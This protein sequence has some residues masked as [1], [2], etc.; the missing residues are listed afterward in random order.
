MPTYGYVFAFDPTGKFIGLSAEG[1]LRNWPEGAVLREARAKPDAITGLVQA[2]T[3]D[4]PACLQGI[5]W[6]RL[7]VAGEKLNWSW[8]TL[9]SV[10]AGKVPQPDLRHE[11]R[12]P[13]PGLVEIDLLNAG[14]GDYMGGV[15]VNAHWSQARLVASDG[16]QGFA[17]VEAGPNALR[18]ESRTV[19]LRAGER[20]SIGWLRLDKES[21]VQIENN[22]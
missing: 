19:H 3:R 17:S 5:I 21:E 6:Y 12:R 2:W 15:R 22:P 20:R 7:P 11:L 9:N 14:A 8:P 10:M 13:Q 4:R 16:W 1:P 18:F